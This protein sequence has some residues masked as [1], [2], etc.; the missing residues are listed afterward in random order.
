M[1]IANITV[2]NILHLIKVWYVLLNANIVVLFNKFTLE[3][4]YYLVFFKN[5]ILF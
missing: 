3:S 5:C 1:Q 4:Q 2:K